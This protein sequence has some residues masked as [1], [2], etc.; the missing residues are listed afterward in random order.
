MSTD[1]LWK[2]MDV[3][4]V[5]TRFYPTPPLIWNKSTKS[6]ECT[7]N[8]RFPIIWFMTITIFTLS[9]IGLGSSILHLIILHNEN[10][11]RLDEVGMTR[12]SL[13]IA[14]TILI[15]ISFIH[16]ICIAIVLLIHGNEIA[17]G[18]NSVRKFELY[19]L[20]HQSKFT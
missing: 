13:E 17:P 15:L 8:T 12:F 10:Y 14:V 5:L 7:L 1:L 9:P 3:F 6:F 11:E 19:I 18:V 4:S 20:S 16:S 2:S